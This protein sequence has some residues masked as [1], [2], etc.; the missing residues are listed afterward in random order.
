M[1]NNTRL[2]GNVIV[3]AVL[4]LMIL[5][6]VAEAKLIL[7]EY[8][9]KNTDYLIVS[10]IA[11]NTAMAPVPVDNITIRLEAAGSVI[12]VSGVWFNSKTKYIVSELKPMGEYDSEF[13][14]VSDV[15][16]W[17]EDDDVT[18]IFK[19]SDRELEGDMECEYDDDLDDIIIH[20]KSTRCYDDGMISV[21]G[22]FMAGANRTSITITDDKGNQH[23]MT[24]NYT[25]SIDEDDF[26][27]RGLT[28]LHYDPSAYDSL[29]S[30][31]IDQEE[32]NMYNLLL[33]P[34]PTAGGKYKVS[35]S[36]PTTES[37]FEV[38]CP[39]DI[40][41]ETVEPPS[42]PTTDIQPV[43]MP[44]ENETEEPAQEAEPAKTGIIE[45]I[46]AF[47]MSLLGIK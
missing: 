1:A 26:R 23:N 15:P 38:T 13:T 17:I 8:Y 9:C 30:G 22:D 14:F 43:I 34:K 36:Y 6:T 39:V 44:E 7:Y 33:I 27:T 21:V 20:E 24:G 45:G 11:N 5:P 46:L 42:E 25:L 3:A 18:T 37:H 28:T 32:Y 35:I 12:N 10:V 47:I 41:N 19:Y 4:I 2:I 16:V 31:I 29:H 40:A